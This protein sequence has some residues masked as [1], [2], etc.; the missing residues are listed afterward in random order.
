MTDKQFLIDINPDIELPE[1]GLVLTKLNEEPLCELH[2]IEDLEIKPYFSNIDEISFRVPFHRTENDGTQIK[3]ELYDLV[4]G[5]MMVLV[6]E[7]KYFILTKPE[8]KTNE[9]TGEIYK[10]ILGFSREYEFGQ[11]ILSGYEGVSRKLYDYSNSVDENGL[12]IGFLNYIEAHTSWKIGYINANLL[13]K[14]RYLSFPK[15]TFLQAMAEVQKT[16]ECVFQYNTINKTIDAYE[17]SQLGHDRG[18]YISNGNFINN[19]TQTINHDEIKTRLYL[20]GKDNISIQSISIT[21]QPYIENFDFFKNTKYMTQDLIDTLNTYDDYIDTKEG[22]YN[23]YLS[24]LETHN[25]TL[26]TK[27]IEL[28]SL[29]TELAVIQS[30]LDIAIADNQS[31]AILKNQETTKIGEISTKQNEINTVKSQ[32]NTVHTNINTLK[33]QINKSNHFTEEQLKELDVFIRE[34]E[35]SDSNYTEDNLEELLESGKKVLKK[36]SYPTLQFNVDVDDFLSLVEAQHIWDKFILGDLINLEHEELNFDI[37]VRLV[38]YTHNPDSNKLNLIFSNRESVDDA[39][40]Y[41]KDLLESITT[42][43]ST[44]DFSRFKWDK[45]EDAQYTISKYVSSAL[46]LTKQSLLKAEGQIP[47][48]D[49]R[50]IWITKEN[51]D[52]SIDQKQ[53]RIVNNVLAIT[54]DD[55]NTVSTA[56]TGDGIVAETIIGKLGAFATVQANQIVVSDDGSFIPDEVLGGKILKQDEIYNGVV[57][58]TANGIQ[59]TASNNLA[60]STFNA[61]EGILVESRPN[62]S[63]AWQ[64]N[65]YVD[66]NGKLQA[67]NIEID[68]SGKFTGEIQAT[69]G[70]FVGRIEANEGFFKGDITGASGTFGGVVNASD[71]RING[72]SIIDNNKIKGDYIKN[73]KTDQLIAGSA[74][75]STALIEDLVVGGNVQMGADATISWKN[76]NNQPFIPS[77]ASDVGALPSDTEIPDDAYITR[78]SK[79]AIT[80]EFINAKDISAKRIVSNDGNST[81]TATSDGVT[82]NAFSSEQLA[83]GH[84]GITGWNIGTAGEPLY[85]GGKGSSKNWV[86]FETDVVFTNANV[87]GL[88]I[89]FN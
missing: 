7:M 71:Y 80:T 24:Q 10:S 74:K 75:I 28:R 49:K 11:K 23:G 40:I 86:H 69:S 41:L 42:T 54:N 82:L 4:D 67:K 2:N 58:N 14:F 43:S 21:G 78:I 31:T 38:G 12:E 33:S 83:I 29:Q 17:I 57:I 62:T 84:D 27:E 13:L 47:L 79:N 55:W 39:N 77:T 52:G 89:A 60:R 30:N 87:R 8:V 51:P 34:D 73:I 53:M 25:N 36:I 64:R 46:D 20:Y 50:G 3:N 48:A 44:V 19:L 61:S 35:Y 22:E 37:Q 16:F 15:S 85:I 9:Q 81:F 65:F 6:N 63:S 5:S 26:S 66:T 68:G 70:K 1:Y 76:V 88:N 72:I 45:G 59:V 56:I 32:I 18:L